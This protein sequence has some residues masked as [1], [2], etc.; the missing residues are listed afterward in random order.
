MASF[1]SL[2]VNGLRD[3]NKRAGLLQWLSHLSL[4]FVC[5]QEAHVLSPEEC[6]S[7][8]SSFGFLS[9]ASPGSVHSRGCVIL[10]R[11][12]FSLNNF[13]IDADGRFVLADFKFR[14]IAFRVVCLYAPNRNPD[15]D[16][17]FAFC[18]SAIDPSVPTLLCGDFN[19]VFDRSLDRR[20]SN[21]FDYTRESCGTLS[22]LFNECCVADVWRILHPDLPG[23]SWTRSDGSLA[24][25]ID[26]IGCPFSWLH[27]VQACDLLPCPFSDHCA[28]LLNC[29]VPEPLPR[30]PGRWKLNASILSDDAFVLKFKAFW[31]SWRLRKNSFG[32][33]LDW[34]DR[35]KDKIKGLVINFCAG[36]T[37]ESR[38]CR[39]LLVNLATHL[40]SKIDLGLVSLL[41]VYESV[42][43]RIAD[44]DLSAA[45]GARVRSRVRWAEEGES[46]SRYFFRLE[47]KHG[48]EN[49]ISAMKNPDGSVASGIVQICDSWVSFY[50][51]LFTAC[52]TDPAVQAALL[53]QL[54]STLSSAQA[55]SCEGYISIDEAFKAL[56]GMAKSKSPGSD[57][58][59]A[60]F[61][62]T[63][64]E[65]LGPDLVEVFNASLDSGSL[66]FSQRGALISLIFKKGDRLEHKN[67]R[68]ISLLNVDY[69]L[70][71]RV[72]AGRLLKVIHQVVAPDQ[73][74]G[75]PGR[76][77]GE[78]V[79]LL[80]DVATYASETDTPLAI[81][82]LD[83][84]KAFDRVDWGFLLAVLHRMGFGPSFIAWVKLLYTDIR[85][86][87]LV[88]GYTSD[89]F[90]PSRG[91]RQ[92]CPLSPLLYVLTMEVLAVNIRA[93]PDIVGLCLP[94][95]PNPLPVL[96]LY[97]DDTSI[98]SVSDSSTVAVFEV[99]SSF[100]AGTG[101]KLNLGKCQGL[102]LGAWRNRSDSPVAIAWNS[103]KIK[104]LGVFVG[105]GNLDEAN[106]R[107]RI[108]AVERVLNSWR[109]RSLSLSGKALIINAL[110][111][112]RIWYVASLV[113]MPLWV[114][115]EL[116]KIIFN[117]FWSGKRDLVARNVVIQSPDFGGFSVVSIQFKVY[118]L[119][120]QWVKRLLVSPNGWT[121][122]LKYWL[123]DRFQ[124]TPFEV[125]ASVIDF[126]VER[127]PPFYVSLFTAWNALRGSS[128]SSVLMVG[129]GLSSSPV[130]VD[131]ISCKASYLLLLSFNTVVPHCV[132]K[133]AS[134]FGALDWPSTWRSLQFMPLDRQVRDLS[135]KVAHGVLYTADRLISFGYQYSPS[136][137][138]GYHLECPEHL[139][140]SCP[141][142]RSGLDWIQ[143]QLFLASPLAP[144]L[145]VR[146]VLF[147]FSSDDLLCVPK[148]FAYLLNVCKFLVWCQRND[149]RFRS[150]PPSAVSLI[151]RLKQ[152]LRFYL[153]LL[154]KRFKSARRCRFFLRQWGANG[155]FGSIQGV[156]FVPS[157]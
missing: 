46:S 148:V 90:Y 108:E 107:P 96:S 82:S 154:F 6:N 133:F 65:V 50:S 62:L 151:A 12:R 125:L 138:C 13:Q 73:T 10:Y 80:R 85:S 132:F 141:L 92:G 157:F 36:K 95:V 67:W 79:A 2:N 26:L 18:E 126:A 124:A 76:F 104:T 74:C 70:C 48:S 5:L 41:D 88:N 49:W 56:S 44:I 59:P 111:L 105:Y 98:I 9:L 86:A 103:S 32:S 122:L 51:S 78:N 152:R 149:F 68:P 112:S 128:V 145:T 42:Q 35:G 97:A 25:R 156:S 110:A 135:W 55:V 43:S 134:S 28:V 131:S 47:R 17:F 57:G 101:A 53:D 24:S 22:S 34:W 123:L 144:S 118:S 54:S 58:L 115:R 52:D 94:G 33:L 23:F 117:F 61:Y 119:L 89:Y 40:K 81:L 120:V 15:R 30:G 8:F 83:Q 64:W 155:V 100:E 14:E 142:A 27:C 72:L 109:S 3:A 63:F 139:F 71:A 75:V 150:R 37:N 114:C 31:S 21:V 29:P 130:P 84:E 4:D 116:N 38:Q 121:F 147:G 136:C 16:D 7:W 137:F 127:L 91:V 129:T 113:S 20:G 102:W 153:P 146:H 45:C 99:Y 19:A 140:F 69:K 1:L 87:I 66:P 77:I 106:W 39:S 11:P 60:E 93:H 143:S